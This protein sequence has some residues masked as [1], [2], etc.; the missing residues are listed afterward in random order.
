MKQDRESTLAIPFNMILGYNCPNCLS[1]GIG[2]KWA[3]GTNYCPK[4]GQKI[5]LVNVNNGEWQMLLSDVQKIPNVEET[6]I[7][8]TSLDFSE[9]MDKAKRSINGVYIDRMRTYFKNKEQCAG[10]MSLADFGIK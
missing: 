8:T 6:D 5:K 1:V 9:G 7:V 10:Q 4:C 3:A 2:A